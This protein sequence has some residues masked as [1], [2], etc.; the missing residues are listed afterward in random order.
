MIRSLLIVVVVGMLFVSLCFADTTWVNMGG[1]SGTWTTAGNPYMIYQGSVSIIGSATLI[2]EAGVHVEFTGHYQFNIQGTLKV[3][4]T[5]DDPVTFTCDTTTNPDRW[6]GLR[7]SQCDDSTRLQYCVI[8]HGHATGSTPDNWGGGVF[9]TD[10]QPVFRYCTIRKSQGQFGGGI[11]ITNGAEPVFEHCEIYDNLAE[12]G[13]G[14]LPYNSSPLF[15]DCNFFDNIAENKG[16]GM[17]CQGGVPELDGC[18]LQNN[19]AREGGAINC[20]SCS[21]VM[22]DCQFFENRCTGDG[23][24]I[25]CQNSSSPTIT[26]C[27]FVGN[28]ATGNASKGGAMYFWQNSDAVVR[29]CEL[30]ANMAE[31]GA[32]VYAYNCVPDFQYSVFAGNEAS[33]SGGA[34]YVYN[35]SL[36]IK[37]CTFYNNYAAET[38]GHI[39]LI[40]CAPNINTNIIAYAASGGGIFF[41][42][43]TYSTVSYNDIYGNTGGEV[44]YNNN[45]PGQGP[46]G[47]CIMTQ[48]NANGDPSDQYSNITMG[49]AMVNPSSGNY[50][51]QISSPCIDAGNPSLSQDPD[52]TVADMG[53]YYFDQLPVV[54]V[55]APML[56][57]QHRLLPAYPNPFNAVAVIPFEVAAQGDVRLSVYNLLGQRVATLLNQSMSVGSY[58]A[59]WDAGSAPSGI[60]FVR[61]DIGDYQQVQKVILQK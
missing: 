23:A 49:P 1:V 3:L 22:T 55:P 2:M 41:Q 46:Y 50:H 47:I 30:F 48:T 44:T 19:S 25:N 9:V 40:D 15:S 29:E 58:R 4:G 35:A 5:A 28:M 45:D 10:C 33:I 52:G 38:G 24:A 11:A 51:L 39:S 42:Y 20:Y 8:E 56:P 17:Q 60:Y 32:A 37:R 53:A 16:G 18:T 14:A 12:Y 61:F 7:F 21:P 34:F 43:S 59:M 36:I 26:G 31:L 13:G 27:S 57:E 54:P 6:G